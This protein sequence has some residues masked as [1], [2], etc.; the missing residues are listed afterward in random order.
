M[1]PEFKL[2]LPARPQR[3][4]INAFRDILAKESVSNE[5]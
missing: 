1:T 2:M 4:L 3:V 5:L